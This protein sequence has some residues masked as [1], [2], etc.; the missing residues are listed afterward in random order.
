M[1]DWLNNQ[2]ISI[3]WKR[4]WLAVLIGYIVLFFGSCTL[5]AYLHS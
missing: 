3:N 5:I 1:R 4:V 2:L